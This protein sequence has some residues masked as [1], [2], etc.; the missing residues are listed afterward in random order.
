MALFFTFLFICKDK[1]SLLQLSSCPVQPTQ[2]CIFYSSQN[3]N[4]TKLMS[5][6]QKND[7][8]WEEEHGS[9][10]MNQPGQQPWPLIDHE[11]RVI[12]LKSHTKIVL[13][14]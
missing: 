14:I 12:K 7:V 11:A 1:N 6:S 2:H 10:M 8:N 13:Q 4:L 9:E 3:E 5:N